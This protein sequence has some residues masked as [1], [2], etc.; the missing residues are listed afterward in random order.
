VVGKEALLFKSFNC[1]V[2]ISGYDPAVESESLWIVSP[3]LGFV[4]PKTGKTVL[5]IIH[6]GIHFPHYEQ[7]LLSTMQIR[8]H[9]VILNNTPKL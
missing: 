7:N 3:A 9:D 6:R 1:E 8:L 2:T 5:L 4:I